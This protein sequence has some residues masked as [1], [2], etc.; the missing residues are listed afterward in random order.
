VIISIDC[1]TTGIDHYHSTRPFFVTTC[2]EEGNQQY[3]E[4]MVN[5]RTRQPSIPKNDLKEIVALI[6]SADE[7][8]GQNLGC[9]LGLSEMDYA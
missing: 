1:E 6:D 8:V 5:P 9:I 4:W 2:D 3:W 7:I